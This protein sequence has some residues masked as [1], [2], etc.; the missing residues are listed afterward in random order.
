M[1]LCCCEVDKKIGIPLDSLKRGVL[2]ACAKPGVIAPPRFNK[3]AGHCEWKNAVFLW[4]NA[5]CQGTFD[6]AFGAGGARVPWFVGSRGSSEILVKK[7]E[8]ALRAGKGRFFCR[9]SSGFP[10]VPCGRVKLLG[11]DRKAPGVRFDLEFCDYAIL[12]DKPAFR[13]LLK[14]DEATRVDHP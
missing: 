1:W 10:Y 3:Y 2:A 13:A 6:N 5:G 14:V 8:D 4:A 7:L 9:A 11:I 12:K